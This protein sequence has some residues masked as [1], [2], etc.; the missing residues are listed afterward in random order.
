MKLGEV[1]IGL[2]GRS[3]RDDDAK[4]LKVIHVERV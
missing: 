3:K 4:S 2:L 1:H